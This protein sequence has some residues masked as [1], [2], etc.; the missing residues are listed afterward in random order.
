MDVVALAKLQFAFTVA[1]HFLFVP[2]SIGI[3]LV[4]VLVRAALLQERQA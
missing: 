2:L 3:G 1:Y 4:V